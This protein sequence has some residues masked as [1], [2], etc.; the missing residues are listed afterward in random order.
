MLIL[1]LIL[2]LHNLGRRFSICWKKSQSQR[3]CWARTLAVWVYSSLSRRQRK[4]G[5]VF[6]ERDASLGRLS[7]DSD[8]CG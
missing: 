5:P 4:D 2:L 1:L 6:G 8:P 3:P 7:L